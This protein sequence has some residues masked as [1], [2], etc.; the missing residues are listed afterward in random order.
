MNDFD[1]IVPTPQH[2]VHRQCGPGWI[3]PERTIRNHEL[4]LIEQGR[5]VITVEGTRH[6]A[7]AGMLCYFFPTLVHALASDDAQP[8]SFHAL[9][10][11]YALLADHAT[12]RPAP[13]DSRLPLAPVQYPSNQRKMLDTFKRMADPW[14]RKLPGDLLLCRALLAQFLFYIAE[15][16]HAQRLGASAQDKV[17]TVISYLN[18][19]PHERPSVNDLARLAHV[20]PD[21]LGTLFKQYT[22][23]TPVAYMNR[24]KVAAAKAL[25]MEGGHTIRAIAH[26]LGFTDEFY[27]SRVFTHYEQLSP[28]A[29]RQRFL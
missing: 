1:R 21:Y 16:L 9:H 14:Q 2:Y 22:G 20:T 17:E 23:H 18:A 26:S 3:I 4:V 7:R 19:H 8:L 25:L 6:V 12:L 29:F 11:E 5:G 15:E 10:F 13:A 28:S 27:F 24:G